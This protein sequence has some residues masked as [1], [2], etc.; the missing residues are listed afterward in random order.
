M[1]CLSPVTAGV[2][3]EEVIWGATL[4]AIQA[5]ATIVFPISRK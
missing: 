3:T 4:V 5:G 2:W 1:S